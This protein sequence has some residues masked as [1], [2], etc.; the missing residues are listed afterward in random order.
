[1]LNA[2]A[3]NTRKNFKTETEIFEVLSRALAC[4]YFNVIW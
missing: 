1:M 3:D 2:H 4:R